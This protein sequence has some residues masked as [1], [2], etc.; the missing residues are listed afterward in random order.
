ML[1]LNKHGI[2]I[3]LVLGAIFSALVI[4]LIAS[5]LLFQFTIKNQKAL[6]LQAI[7]QL[8]GTV[9]PTSSVAV[10]V[11]DKELASEVING[12]VSNNLVK[13]AAIKT[14]A[15]LV[16]SEQYNE[17]INA[18]TKSE[19]LL[20]AREMLTIPIYSPFE[21]SR[22]L[23][24]LD[25]VPNFS[26]IEKMSAD[27]A[28]RNLIIVVVMALATIA[29]VT[30]LVHLMITRPLMKIQGA[31][32]KIIPGDKKRLLLPKFHRYSELGVLVQDANKLLDKTEHQINQERD[33]RSEIEVTSER[34]QMVFERAVTGM[35]LTDEK[36]Y[37]RSISLLTSDSAAWRFII[38]VN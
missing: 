6:G 5:Q 15:F 21:D 36:G 4:G 16:S 29:S 12:L 32:N 18:S 13:H 24:T 7:S 17:Y 20:N 27:M 1:S 26:Y 22:Q 10:Y 11:N 33:L 37:L 30:L 34:F 28:L 19:H 8:S 3:R 35:V 25:I 9:S 2:I 14:D 23:G 38:P 31:L